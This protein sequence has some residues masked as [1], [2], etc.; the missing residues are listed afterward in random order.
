MCA[1]WHFCK[2]S[3]VLLAI[4]IILVAVPSVAR[5]NET[6]EQRSGIG[7]LF[8]TVP[9]QLSY[10]GY[11]ADAADSSAVSATL[12]M[13]FRL[14]AASAGGTELWSETHS[15]VVVSGGL[16]Q[17]LL[18]SQTAFP[19]GLFDGSQLWL[20]TE[21][22]SEVLSPRKPVV[23]TAYSQ[24]SEEADYATSAEWA[25][26]AQHAI[27]ADTAQFGMSGGGWTVDG[28]NV[29]RESGKVG[30]GTASP[31]TELDVNGSVNA[32][33]YYGDGSHLTDLP[34]TSDGDWAISGD[35]ISAA[36]SG[37]VGIGISPPDAKLHVRSGSG[38]GQQLKLGDGNQPSYEWLFDADASANLNITNEGGGSPVTAL[39]LKSDGKVG[40]GTTTPAE[41]L[42]VA[43]VIHS[44]AGGFKF[45]DGTTQ[46]TAATGGAGDG[47]SLDADDGNPVDALY[48][49]ADGEVG[50]G[51]TSPGCR[52][53]VQGAIRCTDS[54]VV[55]SPPRDGIRVGPATR[56]GAF[57]TT[58][59]EPSYDVYF[60]G[61]SGYQMAGAE[62]YGLY[63]GQADM[64]G[65]RIYRVGS[66]SNS[67]YTG[68][69]NGVEVRSAEGSGLVVGHCDSAG[70]YI[71]STNNHGVVVVEPEKSG[72]YVSSP[73]DC[74]VY[75]DSSATDGVF[76]EN[77]ADDGVQ[78]N[79]AH[80]NGLVIL[81]PED[82][83]V[84][85]SSS[86]N[87]GLHVSSAGDNAAYLDIGPGSSGWAVYAHSTNLYGNGIYCY[88]DGTITGSWSK[89]V[90]TSKGWEAVQTL[91]A[92]D[93][94]IVASGMD[95][96]VDGRCRIRFERLFSEAISHRIPV[97][98][99]LTP[100]DRWSGL[101]AAERSSEGFTV[102]S[103][104]GAQDVE[105]TWQAI[106]RRTGYEQRQV[107]N[108]PDPEAENVRLEVEA[109]EQRIEQDQRRY[110]RRTSR[111]EESTV[112]L[113][114]DGW[115]MEQVAE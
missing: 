16:F 87:D 70:V 113:S 96:L 89:T 36:V 91:S 28:D 35:D 7:V 2:F 6:N 38:I 57:V 8:E 99:V 62:Y 95:R 61:P 52:L 92:P 71:N 106:G 112:V 21:V 104:A 59:G 20:Q 79:W 34:T 105:F 40:I 67:G 64:G 23:S 26:D 39:C 54:L 65:I 82:Q 50:I 68:L 22:G 56:N 73:G 15:E 85:V 86:E 77:T 108:I 63:I 31:L 69:Y 10:Q 14:F 24:K 74:G 102:L 4:V 83:G 75:V 30:I 94:E 55:S 46:T 78:I 115:P 19:D 51:T 1:R 41:M 42:G 101:Y 13:T 45:P 27:Y 84:Y 32:L 66:P 9:E 18:G 93:E 114:E 100:L 88:G 29:Y 76:I 44:T 98:I 97:K 111:P 72:L 103:G 53:D 3:S 49:D 107:V 48:V 37:K 17:V 25:V 47:H 33:T 60:I 12:E 90:P 80:S 109:R 110:T 81:G 11:L 58:A 43:G 5:Q